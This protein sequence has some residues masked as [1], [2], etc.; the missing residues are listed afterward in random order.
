[1]VGLPPAVIVS[2][3]THCDVDVALALHC[4]DSFVLVDV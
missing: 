3:L 4:A 2:S 1:M